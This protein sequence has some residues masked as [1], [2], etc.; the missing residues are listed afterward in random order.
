[1]NLFTKSTNKVDLKK[2]KRIKDWA[3]QQLSVNPE[4]FF[5]QINYNIKNLIVLL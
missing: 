2:L 4:I 3:Y 1:M 5:I